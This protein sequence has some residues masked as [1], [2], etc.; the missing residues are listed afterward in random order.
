MKARSGELTQKWHPKLFR[1]ALSLM[2]HADF[3]ELRTRVGRGRPIIGRMVV[4]TFMRQMA[5]DPFG[6]FASIHDEAART[7]MILLIALCAE[8]AN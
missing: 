3:V 5:V 4:M 6:F 1:C 2:K 7:V 8:R